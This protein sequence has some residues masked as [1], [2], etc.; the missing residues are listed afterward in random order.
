LSKTRSLREPSGA[1]VRIGLSLRVAMSFRVSV[2]TTAR[3]IGLAQPPRPWSLRT[4]PRG[5][6]VG[7]ATRVNQ[8]PSSHAL[9]TRVRSFSASIL[10]PALTPE[11]AFIPAFARTA[12]AYLR[13]RGLAAGTSPS[14]PYDAFQSTLAVAV[15]C[16]VAAARRPAGFTSPGSSRV[17]DLPALFHAGSSMGTTPFRGFSPPSPHDPLES[18]CPPCRFPPCGAAASRISATGR[19]RSP[20]A[21]VFTPTMGRSS[22]GCSPLRGDLPASPHTSAGLLSWASIMHPS[23]STSL[24]GHLE[25]EHT[26]ALQSFREPEVRL[27][28]PSL[29][30]WGPCLSNLAS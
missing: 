7:V 29:P 18:R 3:L 14:G 11:H 5:L 15:S 1:S 12:T 9:V 13:L 2:P 8:P 21:D 10:T 16:S 20:F 28:L 19:V 27:A 30:P 24:A 22:P 4:G 17:A 6:F 25:P 23:P 26:C